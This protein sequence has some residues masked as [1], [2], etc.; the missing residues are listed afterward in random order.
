MRFGAFILFIA[1]LSLL[2]SGCGRTQRI[3][4]TSTA[5]ALSEIRDTL[6]PTPA[7]TSTQVPPTITPIPKKTSTPVPAIPTPNV[8]T[9]ENAKQ[10]RPNGKIFWSSWRNAE[11]VFRPDTTWVIEPLKDGGIVVRDFYT[12]KEIELLPDAGENIELIVVSPDGSL[13][14]A[15]SP[16]DETISVWDLNSFTNLGIYPFQGYHPASELTPLA[17]SFSHSN[18]FLAVSGCLQQGLT[19][20][21]NP[22][23]WYS[24]AVIY[25]LSTNK[26]FKELA[27]YQNMTDSIEFSP[28]DRLLVLA[29]EGRSSLRA[30]LLVWDVSQNKLL[31]TQ[32][33]SSRSGFL[34]LDFNCGGDKLATITTDDTLILWDT[35]SWQAQAPIEGNGPSAVDYNLADCS[36][37]VTVDGLH[38]DGLT[39]W[40]EDIGPIYTWDTSMGGLY[41]LAINPDGRRIYTWSDDWS[42]RYRIQEWYI[43]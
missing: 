34:N 16:T 14:A 26:I 41:D 8:I 2:L 19:F 6:S 11:L 3:V 42:R 37:L 35:N 22:M 10:V 23:C 29:G 30:D 18:K 24:G 9:L 31:T 32:K 1:M 28:D 27:G 5:T 33:S 25:D 13:L 20:F 15:V 7:P 40:D 36:L 39:F 4:D 21:G 43:P 12:S 38:V 17:G